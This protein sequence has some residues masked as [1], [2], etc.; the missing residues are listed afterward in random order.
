MNWATVGT[1]RALSWCVMLLFRFS[2]KTEIYARCGFFY[3]VGRQSEHSGLC[4]DIRA[5]LFS[6]QLLKIQDYKYRDISNKNALKDL[7]G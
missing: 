3:S 2:K 5:A 7:I 6:L 4:P 1:F